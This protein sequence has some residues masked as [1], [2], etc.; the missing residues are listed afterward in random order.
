MPLGG[1]KVATMASP[2]RQ[3][4]RRGPDA[5]ERT[6][7]MEYLGGEGRRFQE[8]GGAKVK[9]Q[10]ENTQGTKSLDQQGHR[11]PWRMR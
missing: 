9:A 7:R 10:G 2:M 5:L 11:G 4:L 3:H 8:V 6:M 1:D